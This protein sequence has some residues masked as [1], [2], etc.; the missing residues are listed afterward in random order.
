MAQL[1]SAGMAPK[2]TAFQPPP[3]E[4]LE[5]RI[6]DGIAG[7]LAEQIA[8]GLQVARALQSWHSKKR[9]H[10]H[11]SSAAVTIDAAD[12]V[13][14]FGPESKDSSYR[15]QN[16][17]AFGMILYE[18]LTGKVMQDDD[19]PEPD[20]EL[21]HK[22]G[23]PPALVDIVAKC[24]TAPETSGLL[25]R[26]GSRLKVLLRETLGEK[27]PPPKRLLITIGLAVVAAAALIAWRLL[28]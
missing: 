15:D 12:N 22:A 26:S 10:E 19:E 3:G 8:I 4:L 1:R 25:E 5:D 11:F 16:M 13:T 27:P 9:F 18:L 24:L 20:I 21:L 17:H 7:S 2:R 28:S 6:R 23:L 14:I